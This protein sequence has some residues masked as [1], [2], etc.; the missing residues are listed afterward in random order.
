[1]GKKLGTTAMTAEQE[2]LRREKHILMNEREESISTSSRPALRVNSV[3]EALHRWT[4]AERCREKIMPDGSRMTTAKEIEFREETGY[5]NRIDKETG[6]TINPALD[7]LRKKLA[8][9]DSKLATVSDD[10]LIAALEA[11]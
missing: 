6:K 10:D 9:A 11:A 3:K 1:M 8:G 7:T 2:L 4:L 5:G